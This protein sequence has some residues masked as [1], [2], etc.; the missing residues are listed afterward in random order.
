MRNLAPTNQVAHSSKS[1][2]HRICV[3]VACALLELY[4]N[5]GFYLG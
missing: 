3:Q 2:R 1:G 4:G 5:R